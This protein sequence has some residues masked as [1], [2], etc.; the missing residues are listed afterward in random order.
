MKIVA[1][2]VSAPRSCIAGTRSLEFCPINLNVQCHL[3]SRDCGRPLAR[4]WEEVSR[5]A[6]SGGPVAPAERM[7]LSLARRDCSSVSVLPYSLRWLR[8]TTV[9]YCCSVNCC[10]L[11]TTVRTISCHTQTISQVPARPQTGWEE[12]RRNDLFS[13][14]WNIKWANK[15]IVESRHC[16][17]RCPTHSEYSWWSL[18]L[19]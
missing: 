11:F 8:L 12:H 7:A 10:P 15:A 18:L 17:P 14:E 3:I 1:V 5:V 13:V 9:T 6:E 16:R 4:C 2:A 19:S